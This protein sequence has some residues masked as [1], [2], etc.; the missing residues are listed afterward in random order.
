M[1]ESEKSEVN[2]VFKNRVTNF[3]PTF[4]SSTMKKNVPKVHASQKKLNLVMLV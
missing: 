3:F 2:R 1:S 4:S